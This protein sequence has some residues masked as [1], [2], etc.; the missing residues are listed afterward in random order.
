M[1]AKRTAW[2][3]LRGLKTLVNEVC[4]SKSA[5]EGGKQVGEDRGGDTEKDSV[6]TA[7]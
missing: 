1:K 7:A 5:A 2:Q 4:F 6:L 3:R